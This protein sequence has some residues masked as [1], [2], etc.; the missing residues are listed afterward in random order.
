MASRGPA[1]VGGAPGA[2]H[3]PRARGVLGVGH[4]QPAGDVPALDGAICGSGSSWTRLVGFLVCGA[5]ATGLALAQPA[6]GQRPPLLPAGDRH[7]ASAAFVGV[8]VLLQ[9]AVVTG[10]AEAGATV[11]ATLRDASGGPIVADGTALA[12]AAG[13]FRLILIG[14]AGPVRTHGGQRLLLAN[15]SGQAIDILLP[16]IQVAIDEAQDR[17]HGTAIPGATVWVTVD[18]APQATTTAMTDGDGRFAADLRDRYDITPGTTGLLRLARPGEIEF[19]LPWAAAMLRLSVAHAVVHGV[20]ASGATLTVSLHR[21]GFTAATATAV[22]GHA[23]DTVEYDWSLLLVDPS[24]LPMPILDGDHLAV[25][26]AGFRVEVEVPPLR[27]EANATAGLVAGVAPAGQPITIRVR[28]A[29][30]RSLERIVH[31][32]AEER[33]QLSLAPEWHLLPGDTVQAECR[34]A[35]GRALLGTWVEVG[36]FEVGLDDGRVAGYVEP[37]EAVQIALEGPGQ[38]LRAS[39]VGQADEVGWF[40]IALQ[41]RGS[42]RA[43]PRPGDAIV[44]TWPDASARV[45]VPLLTLET[46]TVAAVA[47]RAPPSGKLRIRWQNPADHPGALVEQTVTATGSGDYAAELPAGLLAVAGSRIEVTYVD[48]SGNTF[49]RQWSSPSLRAQ[50]GGSQVLGQVAPSIAVTVTAA[51]GEQ[52]LAKALASSQADGVFSLVLRDAGGAETALQAGDHIHL[53]ASGRS[54]TAVPRIEAL[55]HR[56]LPIEARLEGPQRRIV[57]RTA[58]AQSLLVAGQADGRAPVMTNR[59]TADPDGHFDVLVPAPQPGQSL[60]AGS[61]FTVAAQ[62][63]Q[64]MATFVRLVEPWLEVTIG[65]ASAQGLAAPFGQLDGQLWR[66]ATQVATL[67]ARSDTFGAWQGDWRS[68]SGSAV[69]PEIGDQLSI[70]DPAGTNVTLVVP[71]LT[72]ELEP[73]G[74]GLRGSGPPGTWLEVRLGVPDRPMVRLRAAV[75]TDGQW[76]LG[77]ADLPP[78]VDFTW[79]DVA[80]ASVRAAVANGHRIIATTAAGSRPTATSSASPTPAVTA[81]PSASPVPWRLTLPILLRLHPT[82]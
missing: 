56:L 44:V 54:E 40:A 64:G 17:V 8:Q 60:P 11:Q 6:V 62:D 42:R 67:N 14:Q 46:V 18:G 3:D 80:S 7:T 37:G 81:T 71:V 45:P 43:L 39:A 82:P 27:V 32:G 73:D 70:V 77:E 66:A 5:A 19:A 10:V 33:Y 22:V 69:G 34:L 20:T 63:E 49:R 26:S 50:L 1:V 15:G 57:G 23:A 58:P 9:H 68:A 52:L 53:E 12:D 2:G 47:G 28:N 35:N 21:G 36:R 4:V 25:E 59:A 55:D 16:T 75:G 38:E 48:S 79:A 78:Y 13:R 29:E 74:Q 61:I 76:A 41:A 65:S 51:R 72:I 30:G 24:G 31:A